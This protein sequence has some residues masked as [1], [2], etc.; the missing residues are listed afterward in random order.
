MLS[1]H[2]EWLGDPL[3]P[4]A[5]LVR[6]FLAVC[7]AAV[8]A[9][10]AVPVTI[11]AL[12]RRHLT[13]P[14]RDIKGL[15]PSSKKGTPIMGG[16]A[17]LIALFSA[18][19]LCCDFLN[20]FVAVVSGF[21]LAFGLIG[22]ADDCAKLGAKR[23]GVG[24]SQKQ[25]Y[26]AQILL[27]L[28]LVLLVLSEA[29]LPVTAPTTRAFYLPFCPY[30]WIPPLWLCLFLIPVFLIFTANAVNITDGLDGLVTFPVMLA[31]VVLAVLACLQGFPAAAE[32]FH[33]QAL[34]GS[35]E[36]VVFFG[37]LLGACGAFLWFNAFPAS[38]FMGDCGSL[39][40]GG[41]LGTAA[42][43]LGQELV[44]LVAGGLFVLEGLSSCLQSY[45]GV[46]LLGRRL[47]FRAPL[48][49]NWLYQ[50]VSEPKVTVRFWLVALFCALLALLS[51]EFRR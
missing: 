39:A 30:T 23:R 49:H 27:A 25:K 7:V 19:F 20:P 2:L 36:L 9:R 38:I 4:H 11:Q 34:A 37:A 6:A 12:L 40:L 51:L 22:F 24:L 42:A 45:L 50:G 1:N 28:I 10:M 8:V 13:E 35:Q 5:L 33:F 48:H 44:F 3:G 32:V 31:A 29:Y 43:I 41:I 15:D 17:I 18:V 16:L 21:G 14:T 46:G 26:L 47:F